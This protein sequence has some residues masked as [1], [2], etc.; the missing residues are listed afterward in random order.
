LCSPNS[1]PRL[2]MLDG[3]RVTAEEV[4]DAANFHGLGMFVSFLG[5]FSNP[6]FTKPQIFFL[7]FVFYPRWCA[8]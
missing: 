7:F 6:S 1:L 4:V 8:A 3:A 5:F 2:V